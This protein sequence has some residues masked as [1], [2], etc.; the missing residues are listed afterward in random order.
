MLQTFIARKSKKTICHKLARGREAGVV[1]SEVTENSQLRT[2]L[3]V[4]T[5]S[6]S[7]SICLLVLQTHD[8]WYDADIFRLFGPNRSSKSIF[9]TLPAQSDRENEYQ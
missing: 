8:S 6:F 5:S 3:D 1:P 2:M 9:T 4:F 7:K